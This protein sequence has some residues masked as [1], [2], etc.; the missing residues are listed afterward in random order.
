MF[1][2]LVTSFFPTFSYSFLTKTTPK[3]DEETENMYFKKTISEITN[4]SEGSLKNFIEILEK[5]IITLSKRYRENILQQIAVITQNDETL[6]QA[7]EF[8]KLQKESDKLKE[9]LKD[10]KLLAENSGKM[11][12]NQAVSSLHCGFM[13]PERIVCQVYCAFEKTYMNEYKVNEDYE[14]NLILMLQTM[15]RR[16]E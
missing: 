15:R 10:Y 9:H 13:N 14:R 6:L 2:N 4:E 8:I 7:E 1:L 11:A 3:E 12:Y 16:K 5:S